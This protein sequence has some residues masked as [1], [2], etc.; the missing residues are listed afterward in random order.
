MLSEMVREIPG[1]AGPLEVRL[2]LPDRPPHA[3]AVIAHPH[4][5]YG[6]SFKTKAVHYTA[7][8]LTRIGVAAVRF[9]FRSVGR[10]AGTFDEGTGEKD[11]FRAVLDFAAAH[12]PG[13]PIMAVGMSFGAWIA[14]SVGAED[15][16][17]SLLVAL[18]PPVDRYDFSAAVRA[19]KP[20]FI[21]H[22]EEDELV[23]VKL[24]RKFY[25]ELEEPRELVV[26]EHASHVF[27]GRASL[28]AEA[29]EGLL[30]EFEHQVAATG[31]TAAAGHDDR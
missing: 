9:N 3:V 11:D 23:P 26:V 24:V 4:P 8:A 2:D 10:S 19:G 7:R 20:V 25:G 13:L 17:V 31:P 5:L 27:E 6:G 1:P 18:A 22:G 29:I 30:G 16:R 15:P 12:Y 21:I 28:L 14:V